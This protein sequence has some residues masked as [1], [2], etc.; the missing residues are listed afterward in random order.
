MKN[1]L[2]NTVIRPLQEADIEEAMKI[3]EAEGWNQTEKDWRL[4]LAHDPGQCLVAVV[5][6][7]VVGTVTPLNF[8]NQVAWIGMMLVSKGFRGLGIGK[9]LLQRVISRLKGCESIKLDATAA[10]MVVYTK[11]GFVK[12]YEIYR[13]TTVDLPKLADPKQKTAVVPASKKDITGIVKMDSELFGAD[14]SKLIEMLLQAHP[15]M[16]WLLKREGRLSGFALGRPGS[17]YTQ[18]GPVMAETANDATALISGVLKYFTGQPVVLD[19]LEDKQQLKDWLLALGFTV[20]RSFARMYLKNN[21]FPGVMEK[22]F[23]IG[24]PEIG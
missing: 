14:R 6:S 20:Q 4:M 18:I 16:A 1:I 17:H 19:V 8:N 9:L 10:G 11:L 15:N 21:A 13:M 7:K 5:G 3:K 2:E 23:L 22:Q 12:E 24:G